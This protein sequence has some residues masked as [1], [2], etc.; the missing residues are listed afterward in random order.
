LII[1]VFRSQVGVLL[2]AD[3]KVWRY[4][5]ALARLAMEL[6]RPSKVKPGPV[7]Q[8]NARPQSQPNA[9]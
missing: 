5:G 1:S 4:R 6:R 7:M 3:E 8:A 2:H 9:L